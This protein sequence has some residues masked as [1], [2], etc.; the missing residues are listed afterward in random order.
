MTEPTTITPEAALIADHLLTHVGGDEQEQWQAGHNYALREAARLIRDQ[1]YLLDYGRTMPC[2]D[3][4]FPGPHNDLGER[5]ECGESCGASWTLDQRGYFRE[6]W[7]E[8]PS[9]GS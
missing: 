2:C 3:C 7:D 4:G 8:V 9:D 5:I 1:S 6:A